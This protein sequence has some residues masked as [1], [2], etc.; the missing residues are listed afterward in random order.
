MSIKLNKVTLAS[1]VAVTAMIALPSVASAATLQGSTLDFQ[2]N[3][4]KI[5]DD[6]SLKIETAR[7]L[8]IGAAVITNVSNALSVGGALRIHNTGGGYAGSQ[9]YDDGALHIQGNNNTGTAPIYLD[10]TVGVT[11]NGKLTVTAG[12]LSV[13]GPV[14]LPAASVGVAALSGILPVA[15]G[16]TGSSTANFVDLTT[17]QT[18][19]GA[20]TFSNLATA[21]AGLTVAGAL[22]LPT[23]SVADAALS[24]NVPLKN[25]ANTFSAN[26]VINGTLTGLTGLTVASGGVTITAGGLTVAGAVSL[27]A[28]SVGVAALSGVLPLANGGTGS[29]TQNFVDLTTAQTVGGA[30]T[31]TGN[32]VIGAAGTAVAN[33]AIYTPASFTPVATAAAIGTT[34]QTF[35]VT[36]LA[37]TD[38]V[39]VNGPAPTSL[40]PLVSYRVSAANTLQ[41]DF[42]TL[43]AAACTPAAGVYSIVAI[44]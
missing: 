31:F 7:T 44:R 3:N 4:S 11:T 28:G 34:S 19:G 5:Y 42:A 15:N 10:D 12:G 41:L 38:K 39:T 35:T 1:F 22:T 13:T 21:N 40:C 9:L 14:S 43:T 8:S 2:Q 24:A 20:K 27:P 6:G 37:A 18:V 23:T 33:V 16:G 29:A 17:A 25:A 30:K 26:Q 32:V 36:N